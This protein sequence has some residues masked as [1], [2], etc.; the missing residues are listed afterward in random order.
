[1]DPTPLPAAT[2]ILVREDAPTLQVY[3][4][5]RSPKTAFMGGNYVF[6]G[7]MLDAEDRNV[8]AWRPIFCGADPESPAGLAEGLPYAVAAV[9]ETFEEAGVLVAWEGTAGELGGLLEGRAAGGLPVGWLLREASARGW[10]F[11]PEALRPWARWITPVGMKK[12]FDARFFVAAAPRD[13]CCS[14]DG[15]EV[16][17]GLWITPEEALARNLSGDLPLAPP[18]LVTLHQLLAYRDPGALLAAVATRGWGAPFAPR[19]VSFEGGAVIVQSWDPQ[20][21]D[22]G[23]AFDPKALE[24]ALLPVGEPFSRLWFNGTVWRPVK[25]L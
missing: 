20:L 15:S 17:A 23:L 9:R 4:V 13:Q 25:S 8:E 24:S 6:P 3:L 5:C 18:T 21:H 12:R 11:R 2:A 19:F 7:G 1:M 14:P 22:P 10:R 16:V